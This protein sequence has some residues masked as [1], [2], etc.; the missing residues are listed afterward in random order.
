M[1]PLLVQVSFRNRSALTVGCSVKA[2]I[3][4]WTNWGFL[5]FCFCLV[6]SGTELLLIAKDLFLIMW[7]VCQCAGRAG[8]TLEHLHVIIKDQFLLFLN[9]RLS[10]AGAQSISVSKFIYIIKIK[11]RIITGLNVVSVWWNTIIIFQNN[12]WA[13]CCICPLWHG[14]RTSSC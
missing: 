3:D 5:P 9:C 1:K 14:L 10:I 8:A 4:W 13:H 11:W 7:T 6:S 12:S 2:A